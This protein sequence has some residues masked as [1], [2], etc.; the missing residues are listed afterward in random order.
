[1]LDKLDGRAP[2]QDGTLPMPPLATPVNAGGILTTTP[3]L[4]P[5]TAAVADGQPDLNVSTIS[6][7]GGG[8]SSSTTAGNTVGQL[9]ELCVHHGLPMPIYDLSAVEGQP[10]QRSFS[11]AVQVGGL[12][13]RG[14]STS[15]KDAKRD[16][17]AKMLRALKEPGGEAKARGGVSSSSSAG[18]EEVTRQ[19]AGLKVLNAEHSAKI[20]GFYHGLQ[21]TAGGRLRDLQNV[22]LRGKGDFVQKLEDLADEQRFEVTFVDV[23]EKADDGHSQCLVQLSSLPVAVCWGTGQDP[24]MARQDSARIALNYLK[25]MTKKQPDATAA[26]NA[27]GAGKTCAASNGDGGKDK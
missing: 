11:I 3:N 18:V 10:H 9:Q 23:D 16:A 6:S 4:G 20:Q 7:Q 15:K 5:A 26:G 1:M 14:D 22:S 25:I 24:S 21:Q 12:E 27:S 17:A 13:V 2:A 19:M 8:P